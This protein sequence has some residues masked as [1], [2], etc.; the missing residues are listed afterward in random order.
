MMG[1][2]AQPDPH[3]VRDRQGAKNMFLRKRPPRICSLL[4][5]QLHSRLGELDRVLSV[6]SFVYWHIWEMP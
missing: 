4:V 2:R 5:A 6:A 1:R 3:G